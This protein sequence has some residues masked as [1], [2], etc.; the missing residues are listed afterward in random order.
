[1]FESKLLWGFVSYVRDSNHTRTFFG[2]QQRLA[3][4]MTLKWEVTEEIHRSSWESALEIMRE[5]VRW[6]RL[7]Q[8]NFSSMDMQHPI[9]GNWNEII[10]R[11]NV[12][13]RDFPVLSPL[14][15]L[16]PSSEVIS[17]GIVRT[18]ACFS[19][20]IFNSTKAPSLSI[21]IPSFYSRS[22]SWHI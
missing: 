15:L 18:R 21:N 20:L 16:S 2:M 13:N 9:L 10:A 5:K 6:E 3:A 7:D 22:H 17:S 1:M 4:E 8:H 14:Q 11:R 19:T 12:L